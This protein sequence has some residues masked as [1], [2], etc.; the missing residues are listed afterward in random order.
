MKEKILAALKTKFAGVP[1]A[2]L[3]RIASKL[4]KTATTEEQVNSLAEGMTLQN[5]FDSYG[6]SRA[7][8]AS[9]TAVSNYEK[10]HGIKDGKPIAE[11]TPVPTPAAGNGEGNNESKYLTAEDVQAIITN[12]LKPIVDT[13]AQRE[14]QAKEAQRNIEIQAK[15]K[16]YGIPDELLPML[17]I[18]DD[19]DLDTYFKD[20]K[21]TFVNA[22]LASVKSPEAAGGASNE[23][24]EIAG[25]IAKGTKEI[26]EQK[27]EN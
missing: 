1:E 25:M 18:A 5:V 7:T 21:Q 12:A 9:Q 24:E 10:K 15:A 3:D 19:A 23:N 4:A 22:G 8:E 26:V 27:K 14:Q 20:A 6:D 11:P 2:I 17:K 16:M 13:V